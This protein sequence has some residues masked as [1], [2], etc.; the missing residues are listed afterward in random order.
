MEAAW[1]SPQ[2]YTASPSR[3]PRFETKW[4]RFVTLQAQAVSRGADA[5]QMMH[6]LRNPMV[7]SWHSEFPFLL[8]SLLNQF[9]VC[10]WR[11]LGARVTI[12]SVQFHLLSTWLYFP[13]V[14][15]WI[16]EQQAATPGCALCRSNAWIYRADVGILVY[17]SSWNRGKRVLCTHINTF[18][19][20]LYIHTCTHTCIYKHTYS[21]EQVTSLRK[22][23]YMNNHITKQSVKL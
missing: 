21:N 14:N 19:H 18:V 22:D 7:D 16:W 2:H 9:R 12:C 23:I 11:F 13:H 15:I 20:S 1:T 8:K 4:I 3:R 6:Y 10:E 17:S 5:Q